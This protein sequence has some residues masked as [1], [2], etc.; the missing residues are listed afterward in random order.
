MIE[1]T[2]YSETN[3]H[4]VSLVYNTYEYLHDL[5]LKTRFE[6]RLFQ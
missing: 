6:V 3:C 4:I 1:I 5:Y 2:E